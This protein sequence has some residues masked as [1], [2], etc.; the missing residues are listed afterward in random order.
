MWIAISTRKRKIR[1]SS[2]NTSTQ[3]TGISTTSENDVK[4]FFVANGETI[5]DLTV[6]VLSSNWKL[7]ATLS[8]GTVKTWPKITGFYFSDPFTM[9]PSTD[10]TNHTEIMTLA[11]TL[12][13][14]YGKWL[15]YNAGT[16]TPDAATRKGLVVNSFKITKV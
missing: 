5:T 9:Y 8:D 15:F 13:G 3:F 2:G 4:A 12:W 14:S 16:D 6:D 7:E 11:K 1:N 10:N